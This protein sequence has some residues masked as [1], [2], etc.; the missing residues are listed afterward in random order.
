VPDIDPYAVLSVP[1]SATRLE[2]ASAYRRLAKRWHP[3]AIGP[4]GSDQVTSMARINEAWRILSDAARRASWD[5]AHPLRIPAAVAGGPGIALRRP[6]PL[7]VGPQSMH[8]SGWFAAA[9]VAI[10]GVLVAGVMIVLSQS[11]AATPTILDESAVTFAADGLS[12]RYPESW[13]VAAGEE[14]A[15]E[16][17]NRVVAHLTTFGIEPEEA[18]T[19]FHEPCGVTGNAIPA[20]E[21]SIVITAWEVGTPP[22]R[23][24]VRDVPAGLEADRMIGGEP[25]AFELEPLDGGAVAWWQLSP[26]GFPDRWFEVRADFSGQRPEL[27]EMIN[28]V[29]SVLGTIRFDS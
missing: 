6:P 23:N 3:D 15:S 9:V 17:S 11:T 12:L 19:T 5:A 8:D 28:Q 16:A 7:D 1:R 14:T 25:A 20:G 27:D 24:P 2:I 26:P 10:A 13:S 29:D 18:C 4:A 22:V 21:A